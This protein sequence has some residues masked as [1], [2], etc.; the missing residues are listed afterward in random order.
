MRLLKGSAQVVNRQL[1]QWILETLETHFADKVEEASNQAAI[2][3]FV[4]TLSVPAPTPATGV[5]YRRGDRL[6]YQTVLAIAD[7]MAD[8]WTGRLLAAPSADSRSLPERGYSGGLIPMHSIDMGAAAHIKT[9]VSS[10]LESFAGE[11]ALMKDSAQLQEKCFAEALKKIESTFENSLKLMNQNLRGP[12]PHMEITQAGSTSCSYD[13]QDARPREEGPCFFCNGPH[14]IRDCP[15]KAE[16]ITL[17]WII[18]KN[19]LIKLGNGNWIPRHP[20]SLTKMQ[21]VEEHYPHSRKE[22]EGKAKAAPSKMAKPPEDRASAADRETDWRKKDG[23]V[24]H[25]EFIMPDELEDEEEIPKP[26]TKRAERRIVLDDDYEELE[27][28]GIQSACP[29]KP[30]SVM[31]SKENIPSALKAPSRERAYK[32][33]PKFDNANIVRDLVGQTKHTK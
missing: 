27:S 14:I 3:D 20:E 23:V 6:P 32:L 8:N 25:V 28:P 31:G 5:D 13:H 7:Y 26:P 30:E 24:K 10:K 19:G 33:V 18:V 17:G 1:V 22:V 4:K 15:T 16:F 2:L 21:K 9:E 12:P 29:E 11:V